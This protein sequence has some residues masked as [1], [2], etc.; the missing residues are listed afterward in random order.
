MIDII[1]E[2]CATVVLTTVG[3]GLSALQR[4]DVNILRREYEDS[5]GHIFLPRYDEGRY[6]SD[7]SKE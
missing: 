1:F 4:Q 5:F 2:V 3:C 6:F 7:V